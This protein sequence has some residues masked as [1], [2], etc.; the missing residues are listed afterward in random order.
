MS[1]SMTMFLA[2]AFVATAS[3]AESLP[4]VDVYKSPS[5]GCCNSWVAHMRSAGFEVRV[6]DTNDVTPYKKKFGIP[7]GYGSCHT[8][9]VGDYVIEGHVPAEQVKRLLASHAQ[10]RGLIVPGMPATSPGMEGQS[11]R[12]DHYD[13]LLL[14]S[15][16]GLSRYAHY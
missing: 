13:V 1:K 3:W 2:T 11:D 16:G 14:G 7:Y 12:K 6:H 9:R 15:E 10:V 5:C 4:P 8:A